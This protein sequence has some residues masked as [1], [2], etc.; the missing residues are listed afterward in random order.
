MDCHPGWLPEC[1][2]VRRCQGYDVSMGPA[3]NCDRR[4]GR[5]PRAGPDASSRVGRRPKWFVRLAVAVTT[6]RARA[7]RSVTCR[8]L[9]DVFQAELWFATRRCRIGS[10]AGCDSGPR[11]GR[12]SAGGEDVGRCAADGRDGLV[13]IDYNCMRAGPRLV[14]SAT[15]IPQDW[16]GREIWACKPFW[17]EVPTDCT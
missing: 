12:R 3:G 16:C 9:G 5:R 2:S 8:H 17:Q 4:S 13:G 14:E 11:W 6:V 1:A 10:A 7:T 15:S